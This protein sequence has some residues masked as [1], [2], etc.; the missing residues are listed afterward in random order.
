VFNLVFVSLFFSML[1]FLVVVYCFSITIFIGI[2]LFSCLKGRGGK[3]EITAISHYKFC[4]IIFEL[5]D[6]HLIWYI[7]VFSPAC[8]ALKLAYILFVCISK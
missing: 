2:A 5:S 3:A 4:V 6:M 7:P 8:L 1:Y